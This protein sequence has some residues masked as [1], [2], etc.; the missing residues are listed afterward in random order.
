MYEELV[1]TNTAPGGV[2]FSPDQHCQAWTSASAAYEARVGLNA[3]P[4]AAP[5][6]P[7]W[8]SQQW[9]LGVA[10]LGCNKEYFHLYCLEI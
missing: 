3:M 5:E 7:A 6:W 10:T 9:W 4:A 1:A 8:K 2:R